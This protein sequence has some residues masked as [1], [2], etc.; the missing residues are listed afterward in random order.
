MA[1][2]GVHVLRGGDKTALDLFLRRA[3]RRIG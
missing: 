3:V 2:H 1:R